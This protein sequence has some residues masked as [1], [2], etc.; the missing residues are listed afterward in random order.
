[1]SGRWRNALC[2]PAPW[3]ETE[4][5]IGTGGF[6]VMEEYLLRVLTPS[7]G[8]TTVARKR[9]DCLTVGLFT[10]WTCIF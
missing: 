4:I 10:C 9:Y 5:I 6:D 2:G 3:A 1:M 8:D 7:S